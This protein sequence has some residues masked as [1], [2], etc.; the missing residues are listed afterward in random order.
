[1]NVNDILPVRRIVVDSRLGRPLSG[2]EYSGS[3]FSY[4]TPWPLTF[5]K[6]TKVRCTEV[7]FPHGQVDT[8]SN[9]RGVHWSETRSP[10]PYEEGAEA[11]EETAYLSG[12]LDQGI[13][14]HT[15]FADEFARVLQAGTTLV[16][17]QRLGFEGVYRE[18]GTGTRIHIKVSDD[19]SLGELM[20]TGGVTEYL[21]I[22]NVKT[23]CDK[24]VSPSRGEGV[25]SNDRRDIVFSGA[26]WRRLLTIIDSVDK[27]RP[28]NYK[29][30]LSA[31]KPD[32]MDVKLLVGVPT[33]LNFGTRHVSDLRRGNEPARRAA[34]HV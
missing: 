25:V 17:Q 14:S 29:C 34:A 4:K 30:S 20:T 33:R 23:A 13:Y 31:A 27:I 19:Q 24:V 18:E 16:G 2:T 6:G 22:S 9:T 3:H 21:S 1:M 8:V 10:F 11:V 5:P 15:A 7:S 26:T 28:S 12:L 32:H